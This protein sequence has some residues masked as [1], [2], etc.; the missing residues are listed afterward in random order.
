M[1]NQE[2]F[3]LAKIDHDKRQVFGWANVAVRKSGEVLVDRHDHV[4]PIDVLESAAYDF[5]LHYRD[6]GANH[7]D[8]YYTG[9]MIESFVVTPEKL[10]KM[11]LAP[12]ALPQG[13]WI[14]FQIDDDDAWGKIKK[15]DFE[16]FSIEGTGLMETVE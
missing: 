10:E 16:M 3:K 7:E 15:G 14:G 1:A 13:W 2:S 6:A 8:G 4:I 12:D 9:K 11:G 5:A